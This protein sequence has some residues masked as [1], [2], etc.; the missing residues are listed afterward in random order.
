MNVFS[1]V[2][3]ERTVALILAIGWALV[4]FVAQGIVIGLVVGSLLWALKRRSPDVRYGV[5]CAGLIAMALCPL[6]TAARILQA[7]PT[8]PARSA[9]G[10]SGAVAGRSQNRLPRPDS[11]VE[12]KRTDRAEMAEGSSASGRA[13]ISA[14]IDPMTAPKIAPRWRERLEAFLPAIVA[15]WLI[16]VMVMALR[17]ANGILEVRRL[18]LRDVCSPSQELKG[19]IDGLMERSGLRRHVSWLLS[20][21]VEV[22]TVI[23]WLRPT[24]LIPARE[25]ARLTLRQIEALLAHELAH[26]R[27]H[28]YLINVLQAAVEAVL[29][30]HPVVW[31]VSRRIRVE[32]ENCCDDWAVGLCGGDRLLVARALFSLEE[33]RSARG[34]RIA[35]SG[36][37]LKQRV[38]RLVSPGSSARCHAE[39]GWAGASVIAGLCC[40]VI[41]I[42]LAAPLHARDDAQSKPSLRGRVLDDGGHAIAGARV[43]L[44]QRDSRWE[45][46]NPV[47]AEVTSERDGAFRFSAQLT[48]RPLSESRGLPPYVLLADFPGKAVGWRII[49]LDATTFEGDI[50]LRSANERT[51]TVVDTDGRGIQ[52]AK[53]TA[54]ILGEHDSP[55][56]DLR[57]Q[58]RL[59]PEDG[60]LVAT[61]AAD[62]RATLKV[63]PKKGTY[64]A[65][66][67]PGFAE[68][69]AAREQDKIRLTPSATLSGR[70]TGPGGE[71]LPGVKVVLHS[72]FLWNFVSSITDADGRYQLSD[73][74]ARGWDMSLWAPDQKGD[75]KYK[76]W[77]DDDRF[78]IP[79]QSLTIEPAAKST[80]DLQA[81]PAGVIRV[82]LVEQG[83]NKPVSGARIW[84]SDAESQTSARFNS[85]TDKL[86]RATFY[87]APS[88]IYL[89]M[90][91]PPAGLY[92]KRQPREGTNTTASFEFAGGETD[93]EFVMPA[94]A[95]V[96]VSVSGACTLRDGSPA[97]DAAVIVDTGYLATSEGTYTNRTCR[98]GDDGRFTLEKLPSEQNIQLYAETPDHKFAGTAEFRTPKTDDTKFKTAI[99]LAPTVATETVLLDENGKPLNSRKVN[100]TPKVGE[101]VISFAKRT[102]E[103]DVQG[104]VR[105]DG[106]IPGLSYRVQEE[107]SRSTRQIVLPPGAR[108]LQFDEV[109]VLAPGKSE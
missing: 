32:R 108:M 91:G 82:T 96:L 40:L 19:L 62:G 18:T 58:L 10:H 12:Y 50:I 74:M 80:F 61:T 13:I 49:P 46:R 95:G 77:I 106:I 94:I 66:T 47:V 85:Y 37:S 56:S 14:A 71:P 30:F 75:G 78:V 6:L 103:T 52:G 107:I 8:A 25:L 76:L 89:S 4:W 33:H 64:F 81:M 11:T 45:R 105:F 63:L 70:L 34:L 35:A 87:S 57:E 48:P 97:R 2:T 43:R 88:R 26:I 9:A 51:I 22:P 17:L 42:R 90:V 104:R 36:G 60:P 21:R 20:Q 38:M 92:L 72:T 31:W 27:R 83:S 5:A 98:S 16:G 29:F 69:Y 24:V 28:D 54:Y 73:L 109:L 7:G 39:A 79:T 68:T 93:L 15:A 59:R 23:G 100:V 67:K 101:E 65:A 3:N 44:Y 1:M 86:G 41:A 53:V 55:L 102:F 99:A 84:G